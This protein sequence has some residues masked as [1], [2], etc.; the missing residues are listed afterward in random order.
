MQPAGC[1]AAIV[2]PA[3]QYS[4][5]AQPIWV[6]FV[7]PL[8]TKCGIQLQSPVG[9]VTATVALVHP[10]C[11]QTPVQQVGC[12][13]GAQ[14]EAE[15]KYVGEEVGPSVGAGVGAAVGAG[16][17]VARSSRLKSFC[18]KYTLSMTE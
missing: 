16:V 11:W 1:A 3:A 18:I 17:G 13:F 4:S 7:T 12:W 5:A 8:L 15:Q 2:V 14:S 6:R 10:H 9:I